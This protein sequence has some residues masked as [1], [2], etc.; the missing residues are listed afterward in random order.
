MRG[1]HRGKLMRNLV[2]D[3][4]L[5]C[6]NILVSQSVRKGGTGLTYVLLFVLFYLHY[7]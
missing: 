4:L 2:L 5:P 3:D 6:V 7:T 1:V